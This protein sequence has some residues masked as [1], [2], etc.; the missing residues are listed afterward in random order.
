M[1]P[2][3]ERQHS[4]RPGQLEFSRVTWAFIISLVIHLLGYGGYEAGKKF[5]VWQLIRTP[6][7]MRRTEILAS[8]NNRTNTLL[9]REREV[10]LMFVDV[11]PETAT[12]E[13]PKNAPFYSD[14]NSQA[15]NPETDKETGVPKITGNQTQIVK[16]EDVPRVDPNK[17]HPAA[18]AP[19]PSDQQEEH[20][21]PLSPNPPGDLAMGKPETVLRQ[22]TG[23][24]E[25]SRPRT[26]KEALMRQNRNQLVGEKMK[27]EGGVSRFRLVPSFDAKATPFGVYDAAFIE[28]VQSRWY[29]LLDNFSYDGYRRGKVVVQFH[30]TYDGRITDMQVLENTVGEV[31]GLLCQ[32]AVLDPAPYDKWPREMR[33]MIDQDY[34]IITF[35]FYYN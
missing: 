25:Q 3:G 14:K 30:L 29:D 31:L 4:L 6:A 24:A 20:A 16:A 21:K 33:L 8:S 2:S 12:A 13:P 7:W 22:D 19:A 17:L 34:R 9:A 23:T 1:T 26:I 32:K 35:N 18:P 27:Q 5:G 11:N 28:I 15:A 10:P